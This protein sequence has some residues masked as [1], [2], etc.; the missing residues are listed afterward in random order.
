LAKTIVAPIAIHIGEVPKYVTFEEEETDN[1]ID[2]IFE[3]Y[4]D[5]DL[6]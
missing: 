4:E 5:E 2:E 3:E 6:Y 1:E